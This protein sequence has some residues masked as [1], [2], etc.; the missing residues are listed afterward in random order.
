[1]NKQFHLKT[2]SLVAALMAVVTTALGLTWSALP[3]T[4]ATIPGA[5]VTISTDSVVTDQWDQVDLSCEWSVPDHSQPGDSFELQLP[6]QLR[7]FGEAAFDLNNEAGETVA[8]A[9]ANDSGVVVITLTDFVSSHPLNVGGTCNFTTQYAAEP[10]NGNSVDLEF[11]VGSSVVR[12]PLDIEGPCVSDCGPT[13]PTSAGKAMWWAD[14]S[15]TVLESIFYMPPME[16]ETND[17]V[18]KDMPAAG[19]EIDCGQITPRV[20][21]TVNSDG[22]I[23]DPMDNDAYPAS[24]K[25]TPQEVTVSWTGLPAGER[26]ELF[27]ITK[28]TDP[29]LN[30]YENTG[31][32]TIAGTDTPVSA[33]T[34]RTHA[35]GTGDGTATPTPTPTPTTAT[36]TP[37]PTPT[38]APSTATATPTPTPSTATATATPTPAPSTAT[39]TPTPTTT[40]ASPTP[41]PT[42]STSTATSTR[43]PTTPAIVVTETPTPP[44]ADAPEQLASTGL[45]GS[46]FILAAAVL[47]AVGSL[48]AFVGARR[49]A[50]RQ[51]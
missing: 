35:G 49:A 16:S 4:A 18:V 17:V 28:V 5:V 37:T 12:V 30:K 38:P 44:A 42:A 23:I 19:M 9:V 26:V 14:A 25:C 34:K 11:T 6:P 20:G 47:L 39:P 31:I 43:S 1:M 29:K 15:Q 41:T 36:P 46:A 45:Q 33:E 40:A 48:L 2:A 22:N 51:H 7:W 27:V 21:R 8:T 24:I 50:S 32:V 10:G 13:P 3:A